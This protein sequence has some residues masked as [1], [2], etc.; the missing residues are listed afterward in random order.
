MLAPMNGLRQQVSEAI[1]VWEPITSCF[2]HNVGWFS[3]LLQ[4]FH[5]AQK[6]FPHGDDR[7]V[8]HTEMFP[9]AVEDRPHALGRAGI[10]VEKVL[11]AREV[12]RLLHLSILQIVVAG[13]TNTEIIRTDLFA[14]MNFVFLYRT[15]TVKTDVVAPGVS[16]VDGDV[17]VDLEVIQLVRGSAG[18]A[19][20]VNGRYKGGLANIVRFIGAMSRGD[21]ADA[22]VRF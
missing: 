7:F 20:T 9:T 22:E 8:A 12:H 17:G 15:A 19:T 21:R 1:N 16:V 10:M 18:G 2:A 6:K 5:A 3:A 13:V 14:P 11:D 4:R